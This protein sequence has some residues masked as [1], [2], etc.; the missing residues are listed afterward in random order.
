MAFVLENRHTGE[1]LQMWRE[2][3]EDGQEVLRLRGSLPPGREGPPPHVHAGQAEDGM[4]TA[5]VLRAQVGGEQK[6]VRAG[7]SAVFPAGVAHA[8]WNGGPELL[9]FEGRAVPAG[10][11]D[12]YLQG[13]FAVLNA[14]EKD[15]PSVFHFAH[16]A[17]RH[18]HTQRTEQ[19][20]VLVQRLLLPLIVLLGHVL[21][22]YR[23]DAWPGAPAMCTGAPR[24]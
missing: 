6:T 10:D 5:G 1:K 21:G 16:V 8:W 24:V 4:V 18:R 17:W 12:R 3:G 2:L 20:P 9:E 15:R 7:E 11:L 13:V 19:P 14:S 23:G 22:K